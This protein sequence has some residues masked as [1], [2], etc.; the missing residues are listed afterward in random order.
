MQWVGK[1]L[2]SHTP[3]GAVPSARAGL[4]TGFGMGPGVPWPLGSPTPCCSSPSS[5]PHAYTLTRSTPEHRTPRSTSRSPRPLVPVSCRCCHP[6]TSGLSNWSSTSGLPPFQ[7]GASRLRVRF[8]L[9]CFQRFSPPELA[10]RL[11]ARQRNRH[12]SAPSTPVLSY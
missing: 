6:S 11:C 1:D 10:T 2:R 12:T 3:A 8:P 4:T 7:D 9:R 5:P